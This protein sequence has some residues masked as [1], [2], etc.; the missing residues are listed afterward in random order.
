M[1]YILDWSWYIFR[2]YYALP[3]MKNSNWEDIAAV[4]WF[5]RMLLKILQ[6][7]PEKFLIA[8]D[9]WW[10]TKRHEQ[11][12][13]YKANRPKMPNEFKNQIKV[14]KDIINRINIPFIWYQWYEADDI[15]YTIAKN[16]K[17]KST[18][19]SSDK[20]LKQLLSD[21]VVF[22]D[23][24]KQQ[25]QT[26]K[27]FEQEMG[28]PALNI[29]DYLALLWDS[30]DN[31]PWVKWIWKKTASDL[32]KEY[33][34]IEN[35]YENIDNIKISVQKKLIESKDLAFESKALIQLLEVPDID[36]NNVWEVSL[37]FD[38]MK[39]I[40]VEEL[41]FKSMENLID[42]LKNSYNFGT[43]ASLF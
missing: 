8:W 32:I 29:V 6:D 26:Y 2:S 16:Y 35:I 10:K 5:F 39:K 33:W 40:L 4:Y 19:I 7:K 34:T 21:K 20:D 14:I 27:D 25:T 38:L 42:N 12:E 3:E 18:I 41:N 43:Q 1:F 22:L 9:E 36:A 15:I 23:P 11:F 28:F 24:V 13:E 31:I 37:D 17:W 30:S